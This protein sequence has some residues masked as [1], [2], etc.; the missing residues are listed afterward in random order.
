MGGFDRVVSILLALL[1][2][3]TMDTTP[4]TPNGIGRTLLSAAGRLTAGNIVSR[5]ISFFTGIVAARI[6]TDVEFGGFGA[7]QSAVSMTGTL[8]TFA[9]GL[10]ATRYVARY[11]AEDEE[12]AADIARVVLLAA[13][14]SVC[15]VGVGFLVAVPWLARTVMSEPSL[16]TPL[17]L[18]VIYMV[19]V[20]GFGVASGVL[21][22]YERYAA[23]AIA[24]VAQNA[25]IL[26]AILWLSPHMRLTGT[27]FAH[28]LGFGSSFAL[29]LWFLRKDL[30][31]FSLSRLRATFRT[32]LR[33]LARFC[34]PHSLSAFAL[35]PAGAT[36]AVLLARS[37]PGGYSELGYFTAGQRYYLLILFFSGFIG[38]ALLPVFSRLSADTDGSRRGLDYGLIGTGMLAVPLG[39]AIILAAPVL[40]SIFGPVYTRHWAVLIPIAAWATTEAVSG[41]LGVSLMARGQQWFVFAQQTSFAVA[42][43][44]LSFLLRPFG[45]PGLAGAYFGG[46]VLVATWSFLPMRDLLKPSGR[47]L[48]AYLMSFILTTGAAVISITLPDGWHLAAAPI[49]AALAFA[50]YLLLLEDHERAA[51]FGTVRRVFPVRG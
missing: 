33:E 2:R 21:L 38:S 8:A 13:G 12:R 39:V 10:A 40:M 25:V 20:V 16:V 4:E 14:V 36:A 35:A 32:D 6:L 3:V 27:I 18:G 1:E 29:A 46:I 51:L 41:V 26:L 47:A 7:V 22:G 19:G 24:A 49:G 37:E 11:R 45:A 50:V 23:T 42:L 28:A 17:R 43:V 48:V 31:R 30:G 5:A 15:V 9:L 44:V 34:L